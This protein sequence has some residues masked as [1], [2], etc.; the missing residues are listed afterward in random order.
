MFLSALLLDQIDNLEC[1]V[2]DHPD[3]PFRSHPAIPQVLSWPN[4]SFAFNTPRAGYLGQRCEACF[5]GQPGERDPY[6]A[7][8]PGDS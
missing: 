7:F 1:V 2:A 6:L 5:V 4:P 3:Q 8:L